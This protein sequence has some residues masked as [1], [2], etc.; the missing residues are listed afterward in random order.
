[1]TEADCSEKKGADTLFSKAIDLIRCKSLSSGTP[2]KYYEH[3]LRFGLTLKSIDILS[4][5][6]ALLVRQAIQSQAITIDTFTL[7][8]LKERLIQVLET[9]AEQYQSYTLI[10]EDAI[11]SV[12]EIEILLRHAAT[13]L[14]FGTAN[15]HSEQIEKLVSAELKTI[16]EK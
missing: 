1:M 12:L 5:G 14:L 6:L 8:D 2:L 3:V 11:F 4:I 16:V 15:L 9:P 10:V 13:Y 7:N